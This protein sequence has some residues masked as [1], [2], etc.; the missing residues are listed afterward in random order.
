DIFSALISIATIFHAQI[1]SA[2][3]ALHV[4]LYE[5]EAGT[6]DFPQRVREFSAGIK[7]NRFI[8]DAFPFQSRLYDFMENPDQMLSAVGHSPSEGATPDSTI[9]PKLHL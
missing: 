4:G 2:G 6:R 5:G 1:A 3:G 8:R 9:R 7:R